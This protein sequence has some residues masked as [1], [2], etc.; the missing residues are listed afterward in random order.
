MCGGTAGDAHDIVTNFWR[1]TTEDVIK[2]PYN[3]ASHL[4]GAKKHSE[5]MFDISK[6]SGEGSDALLGFGLAPGLKFEKELSQ[7][8][9]DRKA[10]DPAAE[11]PED[12][13]QTESYAGSNMGLGVGV[14]K[15]KRTKKHGMQQNILTTGQGLVS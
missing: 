12:I 1:K 6:G 14:D 2:N 10:A 7:M 13:S 11:V 8:H 5:M 4:A 9:E 3:I 15:K